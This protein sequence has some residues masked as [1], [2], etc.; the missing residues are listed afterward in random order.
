[1]RRSLISVL[2]ALLGTQALARQASA[3][4]FEVLGTRAAG[5]GGAFVGVADDAS[6][7]YWNPAGLVLG[8]SYFSMLLDNNQ[9]KAEPDDIAQAGSQSATIIALTTLPFGV[10]YYRLSATTLTPTADPQSRPARTI[11]DPP[12]RRD[13]RAVAHG[14]YCRRVDAEMGARFGGVGGGSDQGTAMISLTVPVS[15]PTR[16]R[17]SSTRTSASW[18]CS[19]PSERA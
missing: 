13:L 1:M 14:S 7:V 4:T 18:P 12:R 9:G 3:Q 19:A 17:T 5:M 16:R 15:C 11:D 10:T 8:G 6:A 2:L